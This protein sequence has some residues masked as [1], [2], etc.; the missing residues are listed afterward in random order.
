ME[1]P[2]KIEDA[3]NHNEPYIMAAYLLELVGLFSTY[4]QKY[5]SSTDKILS[6]D[7]RL[8]QARINLTYCVKTVLN[9]GLG[10]LGLEAPEK[11]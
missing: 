10:I 3:A 7:L 1:F 6:D 4:Y 2:D 11:M 8:R 9:S 5:K